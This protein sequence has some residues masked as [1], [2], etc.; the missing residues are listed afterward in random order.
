MGIPANDLRMTP[1]DFDAIVIGGGITGAGILRDLALRGARALL[2]E[3]GALGHGTTASSSH[4]IHG[5]LRYLLYDRLTTHATCW[6]SGHIV[7]IARPFL[8]RLPIVWPVYRDHRRGRDT[9]E[10]LLESYDGFQPLK[11]GKKHLWL[12]AGE[13]RKLVPGLKEAGLMGGLLFDEYW[14][15]AVRL[16]HA[17]VDSAC[18]AGAKVKTE[19]DVIGFETPGGQGDPTLGVRLRRSNNEEETVRAS[20]VINAAGPWAGR[21]AALAGAHVHLRLQR[22]SHLVYKNTPAALGVSPFP[23]GLLLE[24]TDRERYVFI[25]PGQGKTLVG[26]TDIPENAGPDHLQTTEEEIRYLLQSCRRYFPTFPERYDGTTVGAR[27]LLGQKGPEKLLS[28]GFRVI[29]HGREGGPA[30]LVSVVGGKM[31]DFRLMGEDAVDV[32]G[33]WIGTL[34]KSQTAVLSLGGE[35]VTGVPVGGPPSEKLKSFLDHHPRV[36]EGYALGCLAVGYGRRLISKNKESTLE[37]V[38]NH[39]KTQP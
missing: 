21:V 30:R 28:R 38:L 10:A 36:R 5:G 37:D 23:V 12:S 34:G 31:S 1:S 14:V 39:Y 25:L 16:V 22:G 13:T 8:T 20:V 11:E 27:P 15:D 32:A 4:L 2:V 35:P 7:R 3:K 33:H 6:D 19:T 17:N 24:A 18:R 9:V 26:P 29:D